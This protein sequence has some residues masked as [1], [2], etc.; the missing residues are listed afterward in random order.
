MPMLY[1]DCD[2]FFA[3]CE[4]NADPAL[5]GRPVAVSTIDPDNRAAVLIAVN[6]AA[7]RRGLGKGE[8]A[9]EARRLVPDLTVRHQRP[10]LYV[11][12]HHAIARALDTVLPGARSHSVDELAAELAPGDGPEAILDQVKAAIAETLGPVITVSCGVAPNAFLA[13]T[14]AEANKPDAAIVWRARDIPEVYETL[15]LADLPGLGPATEARL[16]ARDID[17]VTALYHA[18]RDGAQWAWGSIVGRYVHAALHGHED[19]APARQRKHLSHGRALEPRLRTW[20]K[21]R[22]IMRFVVACTVHRCRLEGVAPKKLA[23]EVL[24]EHRRALGAAGPIAPT[25]DEAAMLRAASALWGGLASTTQSEPRRFTVTAL[26]L[27]AWP[28]RQGEIFNREPTEV[29][30]LIDTVRNR[31]GARAIALGDSMDRTGRYTGVKIVFEHIPAIA[32]FEWLGIEVPEVGK[33]DGH[34]GGTRTHI[35][36]AGGTTGRAGR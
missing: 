7:K 8:R 3:A 20:A 17:T 32:E 2:G 35:L 15:E 4:E 21:A 9:E 6:T 1:L 36:D 33:C 26:E 10:E 19:R 31:F 5:H 24:T 18:G 25:N 11:A 34:E 13:K 14:A 27:V 28:N 12:T 22:P 30:A 29:Q 16:R 23:L